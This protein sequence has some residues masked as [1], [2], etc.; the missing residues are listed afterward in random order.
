VID[1]T[2][3]RTELGWKPWVPLEDGLADVVAWVDGYW[4]EIV[5]QTLTYEHKA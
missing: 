1:S 3:A 5:K 2:R 4:E